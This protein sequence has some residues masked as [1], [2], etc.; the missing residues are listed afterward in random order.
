MID[1]S[2]AFSV[3]EIAL[4]NRILPHSGAPCPNLLYKVSRF[5]GLPWVKVRVSLLSNKRFRRLDPPAKLLF[6]ISLLEA[7]KCDMDGELA[8]ESG[9]LTVAEIAEASG[10]SPRQQQASIDQLLDQNLFTKSGDAYRVTNFEENQ[11]VD[12]SVARVQKYRAKKQGASF[13]EIFGNALVT[14]NVTRYV[15]ENTRDGNGPFRDSNK[16]EE[17]REKRDT[18]TTFVSRAAEVGVDCTC[19]G[20]IVPD[21]LP[22]EVLAVAF[23]AVFANRRSEKS[24]AAHLGTW[25]GHLRDAQA[26][27]HS[28]QGIWAAFAQSHV[29]GKH[30]PLHGFQGPWGNL[31]A[32]TRGKPPLRTVPPRPGSVVVNIAAE[33]RR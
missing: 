14:Q 32:A 25:L 22:A 20:Q 16:A 7:R 26:Q 11:R 12:D 3:G 19:S 18:L 28:W 9:P 21:G 15:N 8:I 17:R 6:L 5:M 1:F 30:A 2:V 23:M 27:G 10:I 31:R 24:Q 29:D 4:H 13:Q 33:D